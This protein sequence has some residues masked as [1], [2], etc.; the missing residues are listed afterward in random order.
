MAVDCHLH[1]AVTAT[2]QQLITHAGCGWGFLLIA[3]RLFELQN[4]GLLII[5]HERIQHARTLKSARNFING[6]SPDFI[7]FEFHDLS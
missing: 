1:F 4:P 2:D 7:K 6:V 5:T 3:A